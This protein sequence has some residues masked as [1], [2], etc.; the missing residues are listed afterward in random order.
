[1]VL[2]RKVRVTPHGRGGVER[3]FAMRNE[4]DWGQSPH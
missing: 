2:T 4:G 1:M 3:G